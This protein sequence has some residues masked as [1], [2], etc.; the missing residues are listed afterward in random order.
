M[1]ANMLTAQHGGLYDGDLDLYHF[2]SINEFEF[3][4]IV[5]LLTEKRGKEIEIDEYLLQIEVRSTVYD[6]SPIIDG[7][8]CRLQTIAVGISSDMRIVVDKS[9]QGTISLVE[10]VPWNSV[11]MLLLSQAF[12]E[13]GCVHLEMTQNTK[14][15]TEIMDNKLNSQQPHPETTPE[16]EGLFLGLVNSGHISSSI[17]DKR[18]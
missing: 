4:P 2:V 9:Q 13:Q 6:C 3:Y 10:I 18:T 12:L 8:L 15:K 5:D 14:Y 16:K 17:V 7:F 11:W 1:P